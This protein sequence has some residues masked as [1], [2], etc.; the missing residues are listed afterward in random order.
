MTVHA[1]E[2]SNAEMTRSSFLDWQCRGPI[3][4]IVTQAPAPEKDIF[5][6]V[7]MGGGV[8]KLTQAKAMNPNPNLKWNF[9]L[10]CIFDARLGYIGNVVYVTKF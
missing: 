9:G 1:A 8:P 7:G 4:F 6:N 5:H 2:N 3:Q 10:Q